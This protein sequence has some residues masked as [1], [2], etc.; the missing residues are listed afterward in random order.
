MTPQR[1]IESVQRAA[2]RGTPV[3]QRPEDTVLRNPRSTIRRE[4]HR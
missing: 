4:A 2:I 1:G 3:Q